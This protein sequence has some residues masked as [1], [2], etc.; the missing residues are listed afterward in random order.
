MRRVRETRREEGSVM[1]RV[2]ALASHL[3]Q[4][5]YDHSTGDGS[6][7]IRENRLSNETVGL[8]SRAGFDIYRHSDGGFSVTRSPFKRAEGAT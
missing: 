2:D 4:K 6:V 7:R 8:I 3:R 1:D 5:G